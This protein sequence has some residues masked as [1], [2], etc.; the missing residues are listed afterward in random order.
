MTKTIQTVP[1]TGFQVVEY[2]TARFLFYTLGFGL[3]RDGDNLMA[4]KE[5]ERSYVPKETELALTASLYVDE[6]FYEG[7]LR[8]TDEGEFKILGLNK[9]WEEMVDGQAFLG[10]IVDKVA[11]DFK[12]EQCPAIGRGR[13]QRHFQ[14]EWAKALVGIELYGLH[15]G[16]LDIEGCIELT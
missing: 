16:T 6:G 7:C 2:N 14:A 1:I 11:P 10:A 8:R 5:S 15:F 4:Y 3:R 9:H 12:P 13:R